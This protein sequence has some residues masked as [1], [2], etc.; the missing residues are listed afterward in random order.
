M[1]L[2]RIWHFAVEI[3]LKY[4]LKSCV[5]R[6]DGF[7]ISEAVTDISECIKCDYKYINQGL[8]DFINT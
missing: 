5:K 6:P 8:F 1:F 4:M 7:W 2:L 3:F